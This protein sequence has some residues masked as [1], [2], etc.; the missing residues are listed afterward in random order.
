MMKWFAG[1]GQ[2]GNP[3]SRLR[4]RSKIR[5]WR[6]RDLPTN[7]NLTST[8]RNQHN[9]QPTKVSSLLPKFS[10]RLCIHFLFCLFPVDSPVNDSNQS[11]VGWKSIEDACRIIKSFVDTIDMIRPQY[12]RKKTRS[13]VWAKWRSSFELW[14]VAR[15]GISDH[16]QVNRINHE[17]SIESSGFGHCLV[18]MYPIEMIKIYQILVSNLWL[19]MSV[20]L[21][22]I[23]PSM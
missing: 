18:V 17:R 12:I 10:R 23:V 3:P 2:A 15:R 7:F 19:E 8:T 14:M 9:F 22:R 1:A 21:S 13:V 4:R 6:H 5:R 11:C 20:Y 16:T